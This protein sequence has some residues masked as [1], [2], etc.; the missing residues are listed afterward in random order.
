[1]STLFPF[2]EL[3]MLALFVTGL[4]WLI[5]ELAIKDVRA[6]HRMLSDAEAFAREPARR[7]GFRVSR[8]RPARVLE[9]LHTKFAAVRATRKS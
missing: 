1:V 3:V 7:L 9:L 5:I 6:L 2:P 4:L 8:L